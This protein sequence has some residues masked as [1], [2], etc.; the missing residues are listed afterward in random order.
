MRGRKAKNASKILV[1]CKLGPWEKGPCSTTCGDSS[2]RTLK[3]KV[4]QN[5]SNGGKDC[6]GKTEMVAKCRVS[7][8][9]GLLRT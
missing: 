7:P 4:I 1:D 3:R 8:C 2:V 5:A 6:E 9:P